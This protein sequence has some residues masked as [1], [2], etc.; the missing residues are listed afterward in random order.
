MNRAQP[1]YCVVCDALPGECNHDGP[2]YLDP[3]RYEEM[4]EP[5][6]KTRTWKVPEHERWRVDNPPSS[7]AKPEQNWPPPGLNADP[8]HCARCG[9]PLNK[10]ARVRGF[11]YCSSDCR[12][13]AAA[14]ATR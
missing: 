1:S 6:S 14:A 4:T 9:A 8:F 2:R 10:W 5:G 13:K 12:E 11:R 3:I 7:W